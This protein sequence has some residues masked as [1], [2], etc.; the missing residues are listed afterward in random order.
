MHC[1]VDRVFAIERMRHAG[2]FITTSE[3]AILSLIS[4]A[5]HPLFRE[6]QKIVITPTP[7]SGLCPTAEASG[8]KHD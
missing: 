5:D 8:Y 3:S 1:Q 6:V 4:G 2:A 7:D